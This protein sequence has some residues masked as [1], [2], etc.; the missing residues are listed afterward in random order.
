MAIDKPVAGVGFGRYPD[1]RRRYG[2]PKELN[3]PHSDYIRFFAETGVPGGGAF[4]LFLGGVAW[5]LKGGRG[6]QRAAL[7]GAIAA[8]CVATQFNAQLYYLESSFPFWVAA[9]AAIALSSTRLRDGSADMYPERAPPVRRHAHP[10][11]R[12][13]LA[14]HPPES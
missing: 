13:E 1:V 12:P 2:G 8:F 4:L 14:R 7:G 5:S 6:S 3:T 9:G 10:G 11:P